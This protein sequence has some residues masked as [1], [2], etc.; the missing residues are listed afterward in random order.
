[1][2]NSVTGYK[3]PTTPQE[4]STRAVQVIGEVFAARLDPL[5][6]SYKGA[7]QL[8]AFQGTSTRARWNALIE[9]F[10]QC[11]RLNAPFP[12]ALM[13]H[14]ESAFECPL[15]TITPLEVDDRAFLF[16]VPVSS[17]AGVM[18][19]ILDAHLRGSSNLPPKG[20]SRSV[21][22]LF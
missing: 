3:L 12:R 10:R 7:L 14:F 22:C 11:E 6:G 5:C 21:S 20:P 13:L 19:G 1:M 15:P 4:L 18:D 2:F 8:S 17:V 16:L 9:A